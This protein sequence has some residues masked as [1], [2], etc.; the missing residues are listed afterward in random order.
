VQYLLA[1]NSQLITSELP[2]AI[3]VIKPTTSVVKISSTCTRWYCF[4]LR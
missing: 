3:P 4:K 2:I 1:V